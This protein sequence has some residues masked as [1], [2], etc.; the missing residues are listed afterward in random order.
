MN[1]VF[2]FLLLSI[3]LTYGQ[4]KDLI[5][6]FAGSV[7]PTTGY[8]YE[9]NVLLLNEY[10]EYRLI[11]Q[12]YRS[13]KLAR[14]NVPFKSDVKS[15]VWSIISDTLKLT[16]NNTKQELV[17][18]KKKNFLIYLYDKT[19]RTSQGKRVDY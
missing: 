6:R 18:V 12:S 15:G 4:K 7:Y 16:D 5:Y 3:S 11:S 14:K 1:K 17:F 2:L 13:K 19:D 10:K 8:A 9:V